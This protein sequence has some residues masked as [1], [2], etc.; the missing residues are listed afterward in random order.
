MTREIIEAVAINANKNER[1]S[2]PSIALSQKEYDYLN[3]NLANVK[4]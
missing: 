4:W 2:V 1:V 3:L